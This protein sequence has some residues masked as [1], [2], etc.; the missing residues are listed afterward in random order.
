MTKWHRGE[1]E[2]SWPRLTAEDAKSTAN[3][4]KPGGRGGGGAAV[5][6]QLLWMNAEMK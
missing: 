6:I 3:Q 2:K 1:A 5:R 4:G